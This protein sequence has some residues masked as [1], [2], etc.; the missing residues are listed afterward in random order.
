MSE[1]D[2]S[3][4]FNKIPVPITINGTMVSAI[5]DTG[6]QTCAVP[7]AIMRELKIPKVADVK[8]GGAISQHQTVPTYIVKVGIDGLENSEKEVEVIGLP[9]NQA[10]LGFNYL[11]HLSGLAIDIINNEVCFLYGDARIKDFI[12]DDNGEK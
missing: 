9:T 2:F 3:I 12:N 7:D 11:R 10:L 4:G 5:L 8:I 1:A 6:A